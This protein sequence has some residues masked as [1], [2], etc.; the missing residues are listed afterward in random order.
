MVD[1]TSS[2]PLA[3]V[4]V[5]EL[6]GIGP[7]PFAAMM[8][9]DLGADVIRVDRPSGQ[10]IAVSQPDKDVLARGRPN[11]ALDL[12]SERGVDVVLQLVE[13]ADILIEGFRPGVMERL[14]LGPDV[15]LARNP[16][17]VFG[18]MTGWG[19][20]GPLAHTAGHDINYIAVAGALDGLGHAGDAPAF[21]QNLLGDFGGGALYLVSGV[22]AALTHARATGRGQVVDCAITDGVAHLLA[23]SLT[24][25]QTGAWDGSRGTGLLGGAAPFYD[26]YETSDGRW[27]S[28]GGLEPQFYAAM[29]KLLDVELP[30]RNDLTQWPALRKVLAQTFAQRTQAEWTEIFDGSDA[31][32]APVVPLPEAA[33][34]PHNQARG[35]Y[36]E[37]HGLVQPAPAPRFSATPAALTTPPSRTGADTR[38]A[39]TAW[40]VDD[41]ETLIADGVAVQKD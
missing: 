15:C 4:R 22:L 23:M 11:V 18:R 20:D 10:A 38:E 6:A 12:K 37:H 36:V 25:H 16:K 1:Q 32:V 2:G 28:V 19:Q 27:M 35:T 39:L 24:I 8:L 17:L 9:A 21:P 7:G 13:Q 26:V 40:G 5:V 29:E 34:Q 31:C 14:G 3:G 33:E 41:V 30:D